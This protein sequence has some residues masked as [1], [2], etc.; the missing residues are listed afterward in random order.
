MA[1]VTIA[2]L[3]VRG[4]PRANVIGHAVVLNSAS[5]SSLKD[6]SSLTGGSNIFIKPYLAPLH[7]SEPTLSTHGTGKAVTV[8]CILELLAAL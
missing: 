5:L 1:I 6:L 2:Q 7:V 8:P 3:Q 4:Q